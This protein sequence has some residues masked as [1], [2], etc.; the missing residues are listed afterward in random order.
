MASPESNAVRQFLLNRKTAQ[1]GK[2]F[3]VEETRRELESI[4]GNRP[5]DPDVQVEKITV[6]GIPAEWVSTPEA[7]EE[8]AILYLHGGGYCLGSCN[9]HRG[10]AARLSRAASARVLVIEYRLAPE[11]SFP[12]ALEDAV[13]AYRWL[14]SSGFAPQCIAVGGGTRP[15]ADSRWPCWSSYGTTAIR[16]LLPP[17]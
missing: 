16:Y 1:S 7:A 15:A 5:A 6:E 14:I 10:M 9:T 2:P 3:S 13:S 11:N 8:R 17:Y 4:F 12:A